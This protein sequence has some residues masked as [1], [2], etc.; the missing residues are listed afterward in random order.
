MGWDAE[1]LQAIFVDKSCALDIDMAPASVPV[2]AALE[3]R[4]VPN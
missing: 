4:L 2:S 1:T 3:D